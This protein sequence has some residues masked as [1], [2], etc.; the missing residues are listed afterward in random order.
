MLY[1]A[2][3]KA[4]VELLYVDD[5]YLATGESRIPVMS[6]SATGR[7]MVQL[8]SRKVWNFFG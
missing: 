4:Q 6:Q 3:S 8:K 2:V 5:V 7:G 1:S